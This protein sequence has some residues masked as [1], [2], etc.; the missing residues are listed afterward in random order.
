MAAM[1]VA[2]LL[3]GCGKEN[4]TRSQTR[5]A[6]TGLYASGTDKGTAVTK[7]LQ[8][9]RAQFLNRIRSADPDNKTI[10]RALLNE[11]NELGLVLAKE[12][13]MDDVPKLLKAMLAQLDQ[14]FP[15]QNHTVIAYAPTSPP[16][17]IGT[18]RL[19]ARTR[20]MTYQPANK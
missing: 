1:A 12:T 2:A 17:K 3:C 4:P 14:A 13:N 19:D 20:D 15:G 18:A 6:D 9:R 5:S 10:E 8:D 7:T 16:K 11:N